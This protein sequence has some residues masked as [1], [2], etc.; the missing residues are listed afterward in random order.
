M[1][2]ESL[3]VSDIP[4]ILMFCGKGGVGK[5]TCASATAVHYSLKGYKTI[6]ISTDPS[7]S[8]SDIL[9]YNVMGEITNI[10]EINNLYAVELDYSKV[11]QWVKRYWITSLVHRVL[12]R[13]SLSVMFLTSSKEEN[14]I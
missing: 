11:Y 7:P 14:M 3:I 9:E 1:K 12:A 5:T 2:M 4:S 6:L 8:L 10:P 13:S